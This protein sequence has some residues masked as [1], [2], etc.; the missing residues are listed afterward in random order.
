MAFLVSS[1]VLDCQDAVIFVHLVNITIIFLNFNLLRDHAQAF[2]QEMQRWFMLFAWLL[3]LFS[4]CLSPGAGIA[5][6]V[7]GLLAKPAA[8]ILEVTGKTAQSIRNRSRLYQSG[9]SHFRA[10][11]PRPLSNE[12][13]LRPYSWEEAVG[14]SVLVEADNDM[15]LKDEVLVVCK[16]LKQA[17]KFVIV[18]E[19]FVLIVSC[20]SLLDLG[21]PEFQG[22]PADPEWVM[23]SQ[24]GLESI[25]HADTDGGVVHIVGSSPDTLLR[26]NQAH[27]KQGSGMNTVRW[28]NP[29]T[30]PLFQTNLELASEVDG[31]NLFKIL[32][33][34]IE[35][36]K[37][38]GRGHGHLLHRSDIK[39]AA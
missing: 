33:S 2:S 38:R 34:T 28:N 21:K 15:N 8:S 37:E 5:L 13:P 22:I 32:L 36:G 11:L 9:P 20:P 17:G 12:L 1:Q 14:T 23:E 18:T 7:T 30:I 19:R 35:L 25:I 31:E 3:T 4:C 39:K 6:G 27:H 26:T 24:I 10:R 29:P 16:S